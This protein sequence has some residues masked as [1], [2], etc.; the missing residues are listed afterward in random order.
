M[1]SVVQRLSRRRGQRQ[2]GPRNTEGPLRQGRD[3]E[4][5]AGGLVG[6]KAGLQEDTGTWRGDRISTRW[7][8]GGHF[9]VPSLLPGCPTPQSLKSEALW[10]GWGHRGGWE[11]DC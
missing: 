9:G 5:K 7:T 1:G 11:S 2:A 4:G 8:A 6:A 10:V 3:A